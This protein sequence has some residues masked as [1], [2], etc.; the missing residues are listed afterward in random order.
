[1]FGLDWNSEVGLTGDSSDANLICALVLLFPFC[2]R[3]ETRLNNL[4]WTCAF[5][6]IC[7]GVQIVTIC[8]RIPKQSYTVTR[9]LTYLFSAQDR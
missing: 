8:I 2:R 7:P 5:L 3:A 6:Q 9:R 1:M 4:T